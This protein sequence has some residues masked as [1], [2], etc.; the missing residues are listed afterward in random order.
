MRWSV[1]A[2][3]RLSAAHPATIG[4]AGSHVPAHW[5]ADVEVLA[6]GFPRNLT[7]H[8]ETLP[9][10]AQIAFGLALL[11]FTLVSI[12]GRVNLKVRARVFSKVPE[13]EIR[14]D[15]SHIIRYTVVPA[16]VCVVLSNLGRGIQDTAAPIQPPTRAPLLPRTQSDDVGKTALDCPTRFE[17]GSRR[18][19]VRPRRR[20]PLGERVRRDNTDE[21]GQECIGTRY[22]CVCFGCGSAGVRRFA[23]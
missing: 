20:S 7:K 10:W 5:D 13:D 22:G 1:G 19:E 23:G 16:V 9:L 11:S 2:R 4:D 12:Y 6:M 14:T 3:S 18:V 17:L 15:W 8:V 21:S